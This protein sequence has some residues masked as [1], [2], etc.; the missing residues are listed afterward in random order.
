MVD[1]QP[2]RHDRGVVCLFCWTRIRLST[3][4]TESSRREDEETAARVALLWCPVC[5]RE[6]PYRSTE[7]IELGLIER[8][9]HP[10]RTRPTNLT[11]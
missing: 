1:E 2:S 11:D 7:I 10:V 4:G 6:A 5:Q 8:P 3:P 9:E